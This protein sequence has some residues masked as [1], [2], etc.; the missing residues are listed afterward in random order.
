MFFQANQRRL[1]QKDKEAAEKSWSLMAGQ[2][3]KHRKWIIIQKR[4]I[5][6]ENGDL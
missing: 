6:I 4:Y 5:A 1:V 3:V 2:W